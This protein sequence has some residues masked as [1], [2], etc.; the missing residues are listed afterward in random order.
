MKEYRY[1][2]EGKTYRVRVKEVYGEHAVVEVNNRIYQVNIKAAQ[3][4]ETPGSEISASPSSS[5]PSAAAPRAAAPAVDGG[6]KAPMPGVILKIMVEPGDMVNA[7]DK[8][9]VIE[10][11]KMENDI[12]APKSGAVQKILVDTGNSVNTGDLLMI[13]GD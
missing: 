12:K 5:V 3:M 4:T 13:V 8:V 7:G 11:M 10:A 6:V 1:E 2:I 9:M